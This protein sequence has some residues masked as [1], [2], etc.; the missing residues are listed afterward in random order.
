RTCEDLELDNKDMIFGEQ[1]LDQLEGPHNSALIELTTTIILETKTL[2]S[3]N[4][5][6]E[7]TKGE[8]HYEPASGESRRPLILTSSMEKWG[9]TSSWEDRGSTL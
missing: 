2:A 7:V 3:F 8:S 4:M 6:G 1:Y 5:A 9:I